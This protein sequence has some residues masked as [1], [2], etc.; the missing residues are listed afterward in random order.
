MKPKIYILILLPMAALLSCKKSNS[1]K[2]GFTGKTLALTAA[3]QQKAVTDNAFTFKLF[4][5]LAPVSNTDSNLFMSPL[6]VSIAMAMTSNG[7]NGQTLT[8]ID[9][10]MDFTGFT[11][12]QLNTYYNTLIT[13]LP[14]LDPNTTFNIA[15][16]IWYKQ[17]LDVLPQFINTNSSYYNAEVSALDFTS[18]SAINTINNWVNNSTKGKIPAI[19][20]AIKPGD[21]MYI[22]NALYFK[23]TW[24]ERFDAADIQTLP[25]YVSASQT[26]QAKF[27][28]G[29]IDIN[30][31]Y[32]DNATVFEM[33]YSGDTYSMVIVEP[34]SGK[35]LADVV[36]GLSPTEWD[37][38][39]SALKPVNTHV[40]LPKFTYNYSTSLKSTL[41]AL[42][43]GIAFS[44]NADL[45]KMS[46]DGLKITDV[47]HKAYIAVDETGTEAAAVTS[48]GVGVTAVPVSQLYIVNRPFMFAIREKKSGLILFTGMI[49]NPLIASN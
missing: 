38:W 15:N 41:N 26:V 5:K 40:A 37:G 42:G 18:S 6:S 25:F 44:D 14:A 45:S 27:M 30:S 24:K 23:S 17:G 35:T 31:Y 36:I 13:Q 16:S 46:T 48:V 8:A 10:T 32:D 34:A 21:V 20:N 11:Q 1:N 12:D 19:I 28:S 39:M 22:I 43:M 3:E 4:N 9:S 47:V 29:T 7:A 2:P 49:N 33:P